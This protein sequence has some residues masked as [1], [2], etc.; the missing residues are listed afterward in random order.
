MPAT[1]LIISE[2]IEGTSNNKAIELYNG[3]SAAINLSGYQLK[4]YANS[5]LSD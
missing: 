1:D 4:F 3:T 2:Y 5:S